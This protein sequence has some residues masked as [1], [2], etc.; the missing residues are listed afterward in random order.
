MEQPWSLC[1][2]IY[3]WSGRPSSKTLNGEA[4]PRKRNAHN[5]C[6]SSGMVGDNRMRDLSSAPCSGLKL[7]SLPPWCHRM[8]VVLALH[9]KGCSESTVLVPQQD[10]V[11]TEHREKQPQEVGFGHIVASHG[12]TVGH[13]SNKRVTQLWSG[14]TPRG[15][16]PHSKDNHASSPNTQKS[17]D[18]STTPAKCTNTASV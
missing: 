16:N 11:A 2:G 5:E 1:C 7:P 14:I 10:E 4:S 6:S 3:N 9:I 8:V 18:S 15:N 17:A 12:T 13:C